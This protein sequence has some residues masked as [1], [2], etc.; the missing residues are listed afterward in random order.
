MKI[1]T[2]IISVLSIGFLV[3]SI[4]TLI[5]LVHKRQKHTWTDQ[6]VDLM[7]KKCISSSKYLSL[8]DSV[9]AKDVCGCA[10]HKILDRYSDKE[11]WE[12]D[13]KEQ[14]SLI[15]IFTPMMQDC[16]FPIIYE[17]H[18]TVITDTT[19]IKWLCDSIISQWIPNYGDY[20]LAESILEQAINDYK[21]YGLNNQISKKY[22]RQYS[23]Y[24]DLKGDSIVYINAFCQILRVPTDSSGIGIMKPTDWHKNFLIVDDGGD[25]YWSIKINLT[26]RRYFNFIV[27][28]V[29]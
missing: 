7:I 25:C 16:I 17:D 27:N 4:L 5:D 3:Y 19:Q 20:R 10:T 14:D 15:R 18:Y 28:G 26:K 1:K 8:I 29:G 12:L 23:F 22:Y 21:E 9:K 24:M 2:I 13:T 11:I 6:Q